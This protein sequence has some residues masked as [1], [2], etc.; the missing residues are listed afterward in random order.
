MRNN[1]EALRDLAGTSTCRLPTCIMVVS[2]L[3]R[4]PNEGS[5]R[6]CRPSLT[7]MLKRDSPPP[8]ACGSFPPRRATEHFKTLQ[9][10]SARSG[11]KAELV[12]NSSRNG[13]KPFKPL[14]G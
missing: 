14:W 5:S 9:A 4:N 6:P 3:W 8:S 11:L 2:M 10:L 7:K 12:G 13:A 1:D